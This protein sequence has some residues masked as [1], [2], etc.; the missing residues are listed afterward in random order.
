MKTGFQFQVLYLNHVTLLGHE[1][2]LEDVHAVNWADEDMCSRVEGVSGVEL[3][4]VEGNHLLMTESARVV[5]QVR[6]EG[7]LRWTVDQRF[8]TP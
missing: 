6:E 2:R 4:S 1:R 7:Y 3:H 8:C 5:R